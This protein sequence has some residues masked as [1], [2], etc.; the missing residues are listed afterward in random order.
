M[1]WIIVYT[2]V[3]VRFKIDSTF[4]RKESSFNIENQLQ[5]GNRSNEMRGR[6]I[7][8]SLKSSKCSL[9]REHLLEK[10]IHPYR[11]DVECRLWANIRE[12]ALQG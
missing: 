5:T 10:E 1:S 2:C 7:V 11:N 8:L 9:T 6:K 3:C 4:M 12:S